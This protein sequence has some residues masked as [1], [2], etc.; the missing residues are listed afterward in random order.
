M[1]M[2]SPHSFIVLQCCQQTCILTKTLGLYATT[3]TDRA[4][5]TCTA[6]CSTRNSRTLAV[7]GEE[8]NS[9]R[10][11]LP[12]L[13]TQITPQ[14][15]ALA[16]SSVYRRTRETRISF[17]SKTLYFAATQCFWQTSSFRYKH[18]HYRAPSFSK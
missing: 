1:F 13:H 16:S 6:R 10:M 12:K 15:W 8:H 5:R 9:G 3:S 2:L 11:Q 4:N 14:F 7:L 17:G 18:R